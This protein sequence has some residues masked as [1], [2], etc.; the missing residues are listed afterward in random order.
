[1]KTL[2]HT[3]EDAVGMHARPAGLLVKLASQ[4]SSKITIEY[5]ENTIDARGIL[6]VMKLGVLHGESIT[7][8]FDGSDEDAAYEG[9]VEFFKE[10]L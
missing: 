2:T 6:G 1:M 7:L 9:F 8:N 5:G 3:V 10:N 4:Y